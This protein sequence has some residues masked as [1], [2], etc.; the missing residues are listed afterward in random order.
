MSASDLA[1]AQIPSIKANIKTRI[2]NLNTMSPPP[3]DIIDKY[4]ALDNEANNIQASI[5]NYT[6]LTIGPVLSDLQSKLTTLNIE[7]GR[8][9]RKGGSG[10]MGD[11]F[12]EIKQINSD[13]FVLVSTIVGMVF[14]G[15]V[16]SNWYVGKVNQSP[17][18]NISILKILFYFIYGGLL[19]P[20]ALLYAVLIDTPAWRSIIIPLY[21]VPTGL[22]NPLISYRPKT[23]L[24]SYSIG[25][26]VLKIA[27]YILLICLVGTIY[28]INFNQ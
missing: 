5:S 9:L 7:T 14:G 3:Q 26:N 6:L 25:K 27:C 16:T 1:N 23:T 28:L 22:Y 11:I 21:E 19:F 24:E 2:D 4:N 20:F 13:L 12:E 15:I 17:A 18:E 10:L 8:A